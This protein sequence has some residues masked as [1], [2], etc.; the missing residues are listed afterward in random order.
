MRDSSATTP[1][2][3]DAGRRRSEMSDTGAARTSRFGARTGAVSCVSYSPSWAYSSSYRPVSS[4]RPR[5]SPI[6]R[7]AP[8]MTVVL[9]NSATPGGAAL[10]VLWTLLDRGPRTEDRGAYAYVCRAVSYGVLEVAAHPGREPSGVGVCGDEPTVDLRHPPERRGGVLAQGRDHHQTAQPEQ[11]GGLDG[12]GQR[13]Q[14]LAIGAGAALATGRVE[15]DL[16]QDVDGPIALLRPAVE[17]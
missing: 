7:I 1:V 8:L 5:Y 3:P 13:R 2:G 9:R 17:P 4:S 14:R 16:Q 6:L 12:V 10:L 11:P 15:R